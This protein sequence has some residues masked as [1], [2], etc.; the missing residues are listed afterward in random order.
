MPQEIRAFIA[1]ELPNPLKASLMEL[2][3]RLKE[4]TPPRA[5]RWVRP[6]D[7]HLT[8]KFLGQTPVD[9]IEGIVRA[10]S[11]ACAPFSPFTYSVG[12]LG[13][14]P[15]LRRPR[16]IWVGVQEP[17]SALS[18]LQGAIEGACAELGFQRERR[19]FHPHLTLGRLRD[20]VPAQERRAIG[21]LIQR[22][23]AASLGAGA[24]KGI[25]LIRSD[26][27]PTGAV[28]TTL[29][30]IELGEGQN[31]LSRSPRGRATVG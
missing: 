25:S 3:G 14:F 1:I 21:E 6:E 4:Q 18:R 20:R 12:G 27:R 7:I 22:A 2:Q 11:S 13:C 30:E 28:Y 31:A 17:T 19:A 26:L 15:N 8:L 23:E 9:R 16:V 10:L 5:V 29:R 24:A